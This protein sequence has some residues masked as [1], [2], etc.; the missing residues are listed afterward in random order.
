[1]ETIRTLQSVASPALDGIALAITN[2]GHEFSYV[3]L[4]VIA[5]LVFDPNHGRRLGIYV[6]VA[7]YLN[8]LLKGVFDTERPYLID[9]AVLRSEA[10]E[11]TGPG[12]GFP[13][14]HAQGAATFWGIAALY[15]RRPWFTALALLIIVLVSL[16]RIYLGVHLPIDVLGGLV[17]GGILVALAPFL[18]GI[19]IELPGALQIA[20]GIGLPLL[21][22]L[23]LPTPDSGLILGGMAGFLTAPL[24]FRYDPPGGWGRRILAG[25]IG[26]VL[27]FAGLF[28]SSAILPEVLKRN[29]FG[30]FLRYLTLAY[31]G[32]LAAPALAK[33]ISPA[34]G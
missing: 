3:A 24:I 33:S 4:L 2:F 19:D 9:P 32:L 27:V 6:L 26:L 29:P 23:F 34:K 13:S 11:L 7:F 15:V 5:Y 10:A 1:M 8:G 31:L 30:D 20:L 18:D 12:A 21:L 28:G 17:L 22:H 16:S 14:G 25:L